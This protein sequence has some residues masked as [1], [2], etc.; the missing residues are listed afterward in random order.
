[1]HEDIFGLEVAVNEIGVLAGNKAFED[2]LAV[3][4]DLVKHEAAVGVGDH[5]VERAIKQFENNAQEASEYK[6]IL[7]FNDVLFLELRSGLLVEE[8]SQDFYFHQ[9]LDRVLLLVL[10]YLHRVQT[11][12]VQVHALHHLTKSALAEVLNY[13]VF[14]ALWRGYYLVLRQNVLAVG[15]QLYLFELAWFLIER[16]ALCLLH[17]VIESPVVFD[18]V[19]HLVSRAFVFENV[20]VVLAEARRH[21]NESISCF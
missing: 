8:F 3:V 5:V 7:H 4:S 15:P 20:L 18:L 16:H 12:R 13:F 9:S 1:M 17:D 14:R 2:L 6:V 19:Q 10:Y 21:F 11:P